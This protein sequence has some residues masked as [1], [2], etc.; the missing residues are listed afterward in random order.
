MATAHLTMSGRPAAEVLTWSRGLVDPALRTAVD[1]LPPSMRAVTGY[2]L[3]WWD[4][5]GRPALCG[6]GKALRPALVLLAAD[7]V[8]GIPATALPAA[9]AVELV[10]N[11]SLL[12]DD[13]MDGDQTRRHRPTAWNVFGR[14]P[15]ILAGDALLSLAFDVL[16]GAGHPACQAGI[17]MLCAAVS[18]LLDGQH[19]DLAFEHRDDVELPEC[20]GMAA[21]K[22]G[23]LLGAAA[24][25]GALYGDGSAEQIAHLR[26]F[27]EQLGIAFQ[28]VDDLLGIWGDPGVTGKPVHSDLASRKK[29]LPVVAA[30]TSGTPAGRELASLYRQDGPLAEPDLARAAELVANAGGRD[31]SQ[32]QADAL[33]GRAL[34]R[35]RQAGAGPRAAAELTA[36]ARLATHRDH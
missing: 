3:G 19:A 27:G 33:F 15:A 6:A 34:H 22:T 9:V 23:S 18:D 1:R 26:A 21:G 12:H 2:H 25:L 17:R 29:S 4:E 24:G 14:G 16:A 31:W 5:Q 11:F 28:Y 36:V 32:Q 7:A 20:L 30:L 13:V 35:L 10:H 8:G